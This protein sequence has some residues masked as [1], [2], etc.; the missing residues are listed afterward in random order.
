ML[1][2]SIAAGIAFA[3]AVGAGPLH[4]QLPRPLIP[5]QGTGNR[6]APFFDGWYENDDGSISFSFGYSNLNKEIVEIPLGPDNF[7]TPKEYDGRQP[8]TFLVM[9]PDLADGGAAAVAAAPSRR[10]RRPRPRREPRAPAPASRA[11]SAI[12]SA[13]CSP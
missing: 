7:I 2:R 13:A 1:R 6:V 5:L 3:A 11:A 4:A 9:G 10:S 8:T 12:A